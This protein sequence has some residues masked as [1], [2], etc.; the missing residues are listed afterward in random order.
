MSTL[1]NRKGE[2]NGEVVIPSI[3]EGLRELHRNGILH[4]DIKPSN[5][6]YSNDK[7]RII[8]GDCGIS[9]F[10]NNKGSMIDSFRGTPEY[11]PP[12][13]S[14]MWIAEYS[15][16]YDYGAFGLVL[17][18][19]V[20][21]YSLFD[22]CSEEAIAKAWSDGIKLPS[23]ISGRIE[24][25]TIMILMLFDCNRSTTAPLPNHQKT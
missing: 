22:G 20:L 18:R 6:F 17:C 2:K 10:T 25:L 21:G 1:Y 13:K 24:T 3:N 11:A 7:E 5:L 19:L 12:V 23:S 4:C 16:A 8:I 14:H 9:G 15:P